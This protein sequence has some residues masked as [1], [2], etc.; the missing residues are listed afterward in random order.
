VKAPARPRRALGRVTAACLE[1]VL[2]AQSYFA[3]AASLLRSV[4]ASMPGRA[5]SLV[6]A[7]VEA[8]ILA[9]ALDA[10][11]HALRDLADPRRGVR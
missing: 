3:L 9:R 4:A 1:D 8:E 6:A 5:K 7:A 11:V 10:D 2:L